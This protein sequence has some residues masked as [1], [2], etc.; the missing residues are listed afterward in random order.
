[1][2]RH[3]TLKPNAM[4]VLFRDLELDLLARKRISTDVFAI[5]ESSPVATHRTLKRHRR[6]PVTRPEEQ[7]VHRA[8]T[9]GGT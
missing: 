6:N 9:S 2:E 8:G 7:V 5:N 1:M 4:K 3:K